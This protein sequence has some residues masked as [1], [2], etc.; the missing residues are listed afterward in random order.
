MQFHFDLKF[1]KKLHNLITNKSIQFKQRIV[2]Q[3]YNLKLKSIYKHKHYGQ[4]E[5][6]RFQ[7]SN[8]TF[9]PFCVTNNTCP[10]EIV[11]ISAHYSWTVY[12]EWK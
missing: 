11:S 8:N 2:K 1:L 5:E 6:N 4:I 10:W 12:F 7:H 3:K 9:D